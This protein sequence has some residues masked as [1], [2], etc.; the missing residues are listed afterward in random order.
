MRAGKLRHRIT[1]QSE[2]ETADGAGGYGL[3]WTDLAT[4][5]ASVE[6]LSGR[7]LRQADQ[8]QDETTHQVTIRYRSDVV[9]IGK[10]RISF[11]TRRF[12]VTS[13]INPDER[14]VSL[15]LMCEEGVPT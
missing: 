10:Y 15:T 8:V 1:I 2:S 9:P 13:V 6:P 3:A 12:N 4:V 5:W 11:G 14:N 7:E